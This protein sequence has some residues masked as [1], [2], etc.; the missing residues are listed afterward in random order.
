VDIGRALSGLGAAFKNEV[1][2]FRQ[3]IRQEDL[4]AERSSDRL[5]AQEDKRKETLFRDTAVARQYFQTGNIDDIVGLYEDRVNLLTR[6]N[7][8]TSNSERIL[9]TARAAQRDPRMMSQLGSEIDS[10]YET[11]VSFGVNMGESPATY[12]ALELRARDAGLDKGTKEYADF[13]RFNGEQQGQGSKGL[14]RFADGSYVNI[15]PQ[16]PRVYN[17]SGVEVTDPE[18]RASVLRLGRD[19]GVELA[20]DT[21]V[22]TAEGSG[23]ENRAQTIITS[24][25]AAADASS[26]LRRSLQLLDTVKTGGPEAAKLLITNFAGV[27]GADEGE[28][29]AN[30]GKAVLSQLRETFG[31]AFT[32]GEGRRLEGIEARFGNSAEVNRRLLDNALSIATRSAER[33]VK[34]AETRGDYE[35]ADEINDSLEF[36]IF[37]ASEERTELN[38]NNS[39]TMIVDGEEGELV[40]QGLP[41]GAKYRFETDSS[42]STRT[43]P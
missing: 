22:A 35:T 5:L 3:R 41:S 28:L 43:K 23:S 42:S 12:R 2:E 15:T 19:S 33:A 1:P 13:M 21:A 26:V 34:R 18:N 31:A 16:G 9:K 14:T 11:G 6:A 39:A 8:D 10:I 27:T 24:G 20:G 4:D 32:E 7:V 37:S 17:T 38:A 40:Y 25:L 29:S 30:L 36:D